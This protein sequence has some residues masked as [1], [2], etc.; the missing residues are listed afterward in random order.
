MVA[1]RDAKKMLTR[2]RCIVWSHGMAEDA[3]AW[4]RRCKACMATGVPAAV[5]QTARGA[6]KFEQWQWAMSDLIGPIPPP[7][8]AGHT[9][10]LSYVCT[11]L[12]YR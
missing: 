10:I 5:A 8:K 9:Y 12:R 7:S 11:F 6:S 3:E 4:V 2:L 1:H